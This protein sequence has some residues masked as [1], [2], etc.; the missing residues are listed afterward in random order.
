MTLEKALHMCAAPWSLVMVQVALALA[1]GVSAN[2]LHGFGRFMLQN[3][4]S[5]PST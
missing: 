5:F 2:L 3:F 4:I 1:W